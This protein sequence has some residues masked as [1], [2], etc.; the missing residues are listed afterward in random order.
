MP[1]RQPE[2]HLNQHYFFASSSWWVMIFLNVATATF[3]YA[4][5]SLDSFTICGST[6]FKA[7]PPAARDARGGLSTTKGEKSGEKSC[8]ASHAKVSSLRLIPGRSPSRT[9]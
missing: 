8:R 9:A 6:E 4:S 1:S 5:S 7:T 3:V 2:L